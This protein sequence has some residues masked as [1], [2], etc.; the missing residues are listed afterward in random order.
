MFNVLI[1]L[2][3]YLAFCLELSPQLQLFNGP[4][5]EWWQTFSFVFGH[6][7][8][9]HWSGNALMLLVLAPF[10]QSLGWKYI[11]GV[12]AMLGCCGLGMYLFGPHLIAQPDGT[13]EL[14]NCVY[15]ASPIV[16]FGLGLFLLDSLETRVQVLMALA[17][18]GA[19]GVWVYVQAWTM[20]HS[21][22]TG[23][24]VH[25]VAMLCAMVFYF[26]GKGFSRC[27][28]RRRHP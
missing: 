2:V 17:I 27:L 1:V 6:S 26:V 5:F 3:S 25:L 13:F 12:L 8:P 16:F 21:I 9:G 23:A 11:L 22:S 28:W 18:G 20:I 4:S 14:R 19:L 24:L 7:D 10:T 15:G